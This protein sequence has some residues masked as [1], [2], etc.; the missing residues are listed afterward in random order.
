MVLLGTKNGPS[1]E[2]SEH[3][4]RKI[5]ETLIQADP[6]GGCLEPKGRAASQSPTALELSIYRHIQNDL[7]RANAHI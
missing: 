3:V 6:G 5:L 1:E 4:G 2:R 7:I